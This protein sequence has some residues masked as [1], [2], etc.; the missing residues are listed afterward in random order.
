MKHWGGCAARLVKVLDAKGTMGVP[1]QQLM[2]PVRTLVILFP[3]VAKRLLLADITAHATPTTAA[4]S[5]AAQAG[6]AP[7][8]QQ[9]VGTISICHATCRQDAQTGDA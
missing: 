3:A 9:L 4:C 5:Q 1:A 8:Q 6:A 7:S 2:L